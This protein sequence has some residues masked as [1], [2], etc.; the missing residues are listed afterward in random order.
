MILIL[1]IQEKL[2][3]YNTDENNTL[4][5]LEILTGTLTMFATLI[6]E[7]EE[8]K[9][10]TIQLMTYWGGKF[11]VLIRYSYYHEH[12]IYTVLDI[13]Y[14]KNKE[15]SYAHKISGFH[16]IRFMHQVKKNYQTKITYCKRISYNITGFSNQ[17]LQSKAKH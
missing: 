6:F 2:K 10:T 8:N 3:P 5:K 11:D 14:A 12:Q 7:D 9:Q 17:S 1:R 4:E 13:L 16:C 15:T